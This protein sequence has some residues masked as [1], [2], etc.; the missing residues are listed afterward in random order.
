M[1]G[2]HEGQKELFN[3]EVDL[4]R[5]VRRDNPLRAV[6]EQVDFSWVRDEVAHHYGYN[7]NESVDPVVILKLLFMLFFDNVKSER[8]LMRVV[9]ERL[10]YL[11]FLGFGLDDEIP[12]HSVLSKARARWGREAFERLFVRTVAQAVR[13]GLVDDGKIHGDSSLLDA[14]AARESILNV[15]RRSCLRRCAVPTQRRSIS[16]RASSPAT[17]RKRF[18]S[19]RSV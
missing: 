3:Y 2:I 13:A 19:K 4:D 5:R 15:D 14:D 1:M 18:T 7:G 6:R 9:T 10:D 11:W 16:W 8:E 17:T 12:D